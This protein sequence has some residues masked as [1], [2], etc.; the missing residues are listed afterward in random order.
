MVLA[1]SGAV[2]EKLGFERC[3]EQPGAFG[4]MILFRLPG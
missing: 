1:G 4:A 2:L 3:G